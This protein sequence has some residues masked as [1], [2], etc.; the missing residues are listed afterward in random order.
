MG[1]REA[2]EKMEEDLIEQKVNHI[3]ARM[4]NC[5]S[6]KQEQLRQQ[7]ENLKYKNEMNVHRLS[8]VR[9]EQNTVLEQR[10]KQLDKI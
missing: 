8:Y 4:D 6:K 1:M 9:Q 3:A 5:S 2:R 10:R 7:S